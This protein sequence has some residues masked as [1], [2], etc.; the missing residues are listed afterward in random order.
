MRNRTMKKYPLQVV[1]IDMEN[2]QR[3]VFI[4]KPLVLDGSPN[5]ECEVSQ[6]WFS[7]VHTI[8]TIVSL[9]DL[10]QVAIDQLECLTATLQ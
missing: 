6:V 5:D 1:I 4:G 7:N 2:G 3:G 8:P 10:T 9:D